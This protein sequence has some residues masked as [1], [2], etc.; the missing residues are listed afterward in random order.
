[1][2]RLLETLRHPVPAGTKS[3]IRWLDGHRSD[4]RTNGL[5]FA[6]LEPRLPATPLAVSTA[7]RGASSEALASARQAVMRTFVHVDGFNLYYRALKGTAW[8]WLGLPA[9]F[10]KILQ[11]HHDIQKVKYFTARRVGHA[12]RPVQAPTPGRLSSRASPPPA[13][14]GGVFRAFPEPPDQSAARATRGRPAA[15]SKSSARRRRAR[16]SIS[17]SICSM[18]VGWTPTTV[19]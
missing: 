8:K 4:S 7:G 15:P 6:V 19:R 14:G 9:L 2:L 10:A 18:T 3:R 11:P 13:R 16:T 1:M 12:R 17:R 5:I